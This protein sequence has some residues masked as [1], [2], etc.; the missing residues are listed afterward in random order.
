MRV[1][2]VRL[3]ALGDVIHTWP[4][5]AALRAGRPRM[6]LTWVVEEPLRAMVEGH[7]AV[8]AVVTVATRRWRR[9]PLAVRSRDEIATV[10]TRLRELAPELAIDAQGLLKSALVARLSGA[11][12]RIGLA[13]PWRRERLPGLLYTGTVAGAA[14]CPHVVATNL[15]L[16]RA[17]DLEPPEDLPAPDG[18]WLLGKVPEQ[19]SAAPSAV[20]LPGAGHPAKV[21]EVPLLAAVAAGLARDGLRP[22]VAWGPGER[23]RAEAVVEAA[24]GAAV[25]APPT[26]LLELAGLLAGAAA[27]IGGDTGPVHLAASLGAA[28]VAVHLASSAA[29]NRPLGRAVEVVSAVHEP[30]GGVRG[31]ARA[32]RVRNPT[33]EEILRAARAVLG[34]AGKPGP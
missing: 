11:P 31:A 26:G 34:R 17:A 28:T 22:V 6:H 32:D 1:V 10:R 19:R 29:R 15:A 16:L 8:D 14:A 9:R 33:A 20:L 3:S 4:L 7:P 30:A 27:V 24:G 5:A 2:L 25:L 21:L 23:E 13:R 18:R 12:V